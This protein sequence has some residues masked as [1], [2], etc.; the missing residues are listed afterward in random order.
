MQIAIGS[1]KT[2]ELWCEVENRVGRRIDFYVIN[3]AWRGS[4]E[5][6][7]VTVTGCVGNGAKHMP[8]R[9]LWEGSAPFSHRDYNA[10]IAWIGEQVEAPGAL[11]LDLPKYHSSRSRGCDG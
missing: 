3:G 5:G 2:V 1:G 7:A 11:L 8:G 10:A 6:D 9:V 4:I